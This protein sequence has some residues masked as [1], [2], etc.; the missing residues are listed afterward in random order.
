MWINIKTKL[1]L[2]FVIT[3]FI[4]S[5]NCFAKSKPKVAV[6]VKSIKNE[7]FK[8]MGRGVEEFQ[9]NHSDDMEI[10]FKGIQN[11]TDSDS[12]IQ[13]V[14]DFIKQKVDAILIAPVDSFKIIP[15]L[16]KAMNQ[17]II[18]INIDNK[19]DDRA[20]INKNIS[21]PFV[22]PSNFNGAKEVATEL[23]HKK[24]KSGDSVA[25]IEGLAS[26]VNAKSR[27]DGFRAA[28]KDANVK[29]EAVVSGEWEEDK[30]FI[31]AND[32][33]KKYPT[34]KALLCGND[35]MAIGAIKAI[36]KL[37]LKGKVEVIGYDNIPSVRRYLDSR[38][39]FATVDQFSVLQAI[40]SIEIAV[41]AINK[42]LKQTDLPNILK[43][44]TGVI[45]K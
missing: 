17:N 1:K 4:F 35:N 38:E 26:S 29:V 42:N 31:A 18:V 21:I 6:I 33:L 25:I 36:E 11:E 10:I 37:N 12:Q 39:L 16:V 15:S 2:I 22:G 41:G 45:S 13:F 9:N 43:T 24:L 44:K 7:F 27:S 40:T 5:L 8:E 30:A 3:L 19:I 23:A 32:L 20:L 14:E 34:L 28:M